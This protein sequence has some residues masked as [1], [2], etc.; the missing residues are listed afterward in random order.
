MLFG[1]IL[2]QAQSVLDG[3]DGELSRVTYRGSHLGQW[4]DTVGDDLTNYGFFTGLAWG[5]YASTHSTHSTH[6]IFYLVAG[7]I[8]VSCGLL[9][10][11][12]EYR[13]L[14]RI[15]SGDLLAYPLGIGKAPGADETKS[16][17]GRFLDVIS[18]LF[19]RD[20]FVLMTLLAVAIGLAGPILFIF[21]AGGVGILVTVLKAEAR[22][23]TERKQGAKVERRS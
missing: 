3:C 22:M 5:L 14:I 13:Y 15:G 2:F 10:S 21:A 23:A 7:A 8:V 6:S 1:A 19:K 18:P 16:G 12:I 17:I 11:G 4:L 20:S 9:T